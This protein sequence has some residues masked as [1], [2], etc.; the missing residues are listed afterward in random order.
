[1]M[2][3]SGKISQQSVPLEDKSSTA[4]EFHKAVGQFNDY[5]VA[6]EVLEPLRTLFLGVPE[7]TWNDFF[8]EHLIQK[9]IQ[10]IEAKIV[11][12]NPFSEEIVKWIK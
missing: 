4:N 8:Q 10:R 1:M 12:Y 9:A 5:F 6:L 11:V 7:D 3:N 2:L